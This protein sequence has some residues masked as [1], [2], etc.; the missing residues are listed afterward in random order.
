M[1][2]NIDNVLIKCPTGM[3]GFDQISEGGLPRG[4]TTLIAGYAGTGKSIFAV[5]FLVRGVEQS[6]ET[7]V[8]VSF[9]ESASDL[10]KNVSSF[11]FDL[12]RLQNENRL[13]FISIH[14]DP[15]QTFQS[16]EFTLDG[17]LVR[18]EAAIDAVGAKRV[19]LDGV[20]TLF[21]SISDPQ[22]MRGEFQHL[23]SWLKSKNVTS[24]VTAEQG[25]GSLT[26]YGLEEYIADCVISLDNRVVEQI[27]T[28]RIRIVKYRGSKHAGDEC[29]FIVSDNGF[30]VMPTSSAGLNYPV[31]SEKISTGV[32]SLDE[33]LCGGMLS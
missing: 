1:S 17:I 22:K 2:R 4:R 33:M 3:G 29:P 5:E 26:R 31:S 11:G 21:A 20:E 28:R 13:K 16:G 12:V 18:L 30:S 23:L 24:L 25:S 15:S 8:F 14:L 6:E 7:G 32:E 27:A 10:S 9:E 19:V